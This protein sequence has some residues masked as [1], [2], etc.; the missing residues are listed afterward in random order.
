MNTM[1]DSTNE[2][3]INLLGTPDIG[4]LF[5]NL[6]VMAILPALG[7]ELVFRGVVQPNLIKMVS[8]YHI[9][10]WIT[11]FIFSAIHMQFQG[12][13]PRM[14][15]GAL[16]GYLSF[17]S[18]NLWFPIIA[19]FFN[20]AIQVVAFFIVKKNNLEID[21]NNNFEFPIYILIIS[22]I[23]FLGIG[24]YFYRYFLQNTE[25]EIE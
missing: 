2:I 14:V 20:N 6:L 7:E 3:V 11:A 16:L 25:V 12:F 21:L 5:L 17:W 8:N 10:I 1:E 13:L 19:H 4:L 18:K 23:L 9:A 15:L 22:L 24:W